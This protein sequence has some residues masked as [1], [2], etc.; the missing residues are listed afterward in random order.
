MSLFSTT[1][2]Q[3]MRPGLA[4]AAAWLAL[5]EIAAAQAPFAAR[6]LDYSP[7]PGQFV[8]NADLND[9]SRA[10]GPPAAGGTGAANNSK[11]VSLGGFGG[12]ITLGF[13]GRI[14]DNPHNPFGM[15]L[16]VYG[17]A[18]WIGGNP[19]DPTRRFAEA[20]S[21]E[22]SRDDN[23][24]GIADDPWYLIPGSVY[25]GMVPP[26][27]PTSKTWDDN[28]ADPTNPPSSSAWLPVGRAGTWATSA[29]QLGAPFTTPILIHP[30]GSGANMEAHH[31]LADLSPTAIL[32]DLDGDNIAD[33]PGVPPGRFYT[34]PD[35]PRTVGLSPGSG[36]GD[37]V[38]MATAIDP[39]I[40]LPPTPPL[41]W[42]DFVRITTA[43]DAVN[44]P[45]G[46]ISTEIGA[47]ADV[48]PA[49]TADWNRDGAVT[50]QDIFDYLVSYFSADPDA[51]AGGGDFNDSGATSVQDIFDFL[52]AYFAE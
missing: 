31:G 46:E 3:P 4:L 48:R 10:L 27:V 30:L 8:R 28:I 21:I 50:V 49:Y 18:F 43:V 44:P 9:P 40:G 42:I 11:V 51:E 39:S 34:N 38:D 15:D 45:L 6:V 5:A 36:G 1:P 23:A 17:N 29:Y 7:A 26:L 14:Y 52:T 24:N 16:I 32:G 19:G 33:D 20:G 22:V 35:D 41:R 25:T 2:M 47:V 37:A 13:D 12:T